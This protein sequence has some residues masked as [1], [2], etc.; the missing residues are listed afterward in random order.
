MLRVPHSPYSAA[1]YKFRWVRPEE[2]C[3][4]TD[5]QVRLSSGR[6]RLQGSIH[7]E[8][9]SVPRGDLYF[10]LQV[11]PPIEEQFADVSTTEDVATFSTQFGLLR[12]SIFQEDIQ[13][14]R[15]TG[16]APGESVQEWLQWAG[17]VREVLAV[18]RALQ[19]MDLPRLR[20]RFAW[21]ELEKAY[22]VS[23]GSGQEMQLLR[24]FSK[25][26]NSAI[27][28]P[29]KYGD[30]VQPARFLLAR[31]LTRTLRNE[32]SYVVSGDQP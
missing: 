16:S 27:S 21:K 14:V 3:I 24:H 20:D 28:T 15:A 4:V 7:D 10:P 25:S 2:P 23:Y 5:G 12:R 8:V 30:L 13:Q 26:G 11:D 18:W 32:I 17:E 1:A 19:T 31:T 29:W 22:Q 9:E 6:F